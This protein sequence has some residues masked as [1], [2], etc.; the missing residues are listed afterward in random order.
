MTNSDYTG[1][2][3]FFSD[4]Q[5]K[6]LTEKVIP[7]PSQFNN[8]ITGSLLHFMK[9]RGAKLVWQ[10]HDISK[11][12]NTNWKGFYRDRSYGL[13]EVDIFVPTFSLAFRIASMNANGWEYVNNYVIQSTSGEV[14]HRYLLKKKAK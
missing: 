9:S 14:T 6:K 8:S 13:V 10:T 1:D 11:E 2:L 4:L 3:S 7:P 5:K 12:L